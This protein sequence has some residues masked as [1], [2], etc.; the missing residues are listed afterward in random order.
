MERGPLLALGAIGVLALL[1]S[2]QASAS[3]SPAPGPYGR[4]YAPPTPYAPPW[5]PWGP[6]PQ[7]PYTGQAGQPVYVPVEV[8]DP[9]TGES[10][11][12][13]TATLPGEFDYPEEP[14][15]AIL[16]GEWDYPPGFPPTIPGEFDYPYPEDTMPAPANDGT[17]LPAPAPLD[18]SANVAAFLALIRTTEGTERAPNP[19]AV[20]YAYKVTANTDPGS[21]HPADP[22]LGVYRW[23]GERLPD[24]YCIAA[25]IAPPCVSTA[26]GA[27]QFIWPTWN[28][29]S[30]GSDFSP[31][32]QDAAAIELLA[33]L[34]ALAAIE[35]GDFVGALQRASQM[36][37]WAS[38]PY[39][40]SGQPRVTVQQ[41]V[42]IF[43]AA[44]GDVS[45]TATAGGSTVGIRG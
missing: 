13:Y 21:R 35:R 40:P 15:P 34:G 12:E 8:T 42:D 16:P 36:A 44:G 4:P 14:R 5:T 6:I 43:L 22:A 39:S 3:A 17:S 24:S 30:G 28:N 41:A 9:A 25:G 1:A 10:W 23:R 33:Q 27:Y 32:S 11:I 38:L 26:A 20:T 45:S 7:G 18:V 37:G 19:Y 2:R 29:L 31:S